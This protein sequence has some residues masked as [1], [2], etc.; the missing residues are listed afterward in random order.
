MKTMMV[1]ATV[2]AAGSLVVAPVG[3]KVHHASPCKR[4]Q[5]ELAAGKTPEQVA[6]DMKVSA[7]TVKRCTPSAKGQSAGTTAK[8][9]K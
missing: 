8:A 1:L 2:L 6:Q 7:A 3:A 5:A 4:I 9:T